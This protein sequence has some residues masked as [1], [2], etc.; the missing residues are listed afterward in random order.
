MPITLLLDLDDTLLDTDTRAFL[1]A[2]YDSL[3]KHLS[4]LV[5]PAAMLEAFHSGVEIMRANT[6]PARTLRDVFEAHFYTRLGVEPEALQTAVA[7]FYSKVFPGLGRLAR[8]I[9]GGRDLVDWALEAGH[10][11]VIATDPLFPLQATE[12]RVRWAGLDPAGFSLISAFETFHFSKSHIAYFA[13]VL[14]RLG[15]PDRQI[16]M[17]GND[18]ERDLIPA[19]AL[20]LTTFRVNGPPVRRDGI[21]PTSGLPSGATVDGDLMELMDWLYSKPLET[22]VPSFKTRDAILAVLRATPAVLQTLTANLTPEMWKLERSATEWAMIELVC[23]L[24]DTE[25]EVHAAQVKTLV[26]SPIPFVARPD[27]AVWAKQRRYL[28]EDGPA[29]LREFVSARV[30]A[31]NHL[32]SLS[33]GLWTKPAR[34]AIFGPTTFLE[35]VGFMADHDRLHLQQA[36]DILHPVEAPAHPS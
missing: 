28:G 36:W 14:G 7:T 31:L 19:R 18:L 27:A 4:P 22:Y 26:E 1:P 20:G 10:E 29:S 11:V 35:V 5:K 13:E 16:L 3:A 8:P 24:R 9:A 21:V 34:H 17:V 15:W 2:Y 30:A 33:K 12:E 25:R 23:H 32:E 6:D